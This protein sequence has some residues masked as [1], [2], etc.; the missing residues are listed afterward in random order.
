MTKRLPCEV[1]MPDDPEIAAVTTARAL[2]RNPI[3]KNQI[4]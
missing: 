3:Q 4:L 2:A 1:Q